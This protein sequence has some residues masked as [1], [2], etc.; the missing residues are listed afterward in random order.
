MQITI[1]IYTMSGFT[2]NLE[3]REIK[4][5]KHSHIFRKIEELSWNFG[6]MSDKSV[7]F[8]QM[9]LDMYYITFSL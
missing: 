9:Q 5:L 1:F 2:A 3:N 8:F 6:F 7:N 4:N